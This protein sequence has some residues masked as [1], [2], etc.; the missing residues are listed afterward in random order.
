M[1][2]LA[3]ST[4]GEKEAAKLLA[5]GWGQ[6]QV[7]VPTTPLPPASDGAYFVVCTHSCSVVSI[8]LVRDPQIEVAEA[9]PV[10]HYKPR[11]DQARGR[12]VRKFHIPVNG[13]R[14]EA[15]EV[16]INVRRFVGRELLLNFKPAEFSA[17][18]KAR[19]DFAGW[20]ARYYARTAFP[21]EL[22]GRLGK[23]IHGLL[24]EFLDGKCGRTETPRRELIDRLFVRFES[25]EL[26]A[27]NP[28]HLD[29]MILCR[30]ATVLEEFD[31]T[32]SRLFGGPTVTIDEVALTFETNSHD[33]M[34]LS[35]LEGWIPWTDWDHLSGMWEAAI[36]SN[37]V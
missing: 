16:N 27:G 34:Y 29:L 23:R 25:D 37:A 10:A 31:E 9:H 8:S 21:N 20:I 14:F 18:E 32:I 24:K 12:D 22:V 35:E 28:Y 17:T 15:L 13:A 7:L 33:E 19:R 2:S 1:D 26:L 3:P 36:A 6:G 5:L 4:F 30:D 11:S